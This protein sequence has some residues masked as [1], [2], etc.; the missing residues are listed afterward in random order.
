MNN[1]TC[2]SNF[3]LFNNAENRIASWEV[4]NNSFLQVFSD[5][6]ESKSNKIILW[7]LISSERNE[8]L[9]FDVEKQRFVT[10]ISNGRD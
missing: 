10:F 6:E 1:I 9:G 2:G 3:F 8:F 4:N 7:Q 5:Q